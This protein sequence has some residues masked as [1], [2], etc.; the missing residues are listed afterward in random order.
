MVK[1]M[2]KDSPKPIPL[3]TEGLLKFNE[4][5]LIENSSSRYSYRDGYYDFGCLF[6]SPDFELCTEDYQNNYMPELGIKIESV[7]QLQMI[8]YQLE[9]KKLTWKL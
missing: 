1:N 6:I 5:F 7:Q 4:I 9:K 3:T 2:Q 8:Y